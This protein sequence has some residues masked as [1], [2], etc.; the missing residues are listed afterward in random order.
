[1]TP[2][3]LSDIYLVMDRKPEATTS[4]SSIP[5]DRLL[6]VD[7]AAT[8]DGATV[9]VDL[10]CGEGVTPVIPEATH[11]TPSELE[12][13][14]ANECAAGMLTLDQRIVVTAPE[15]RVAR[16]GA[17]ALRD[18]GFVRTGYLDG[19]LDEWVRL[20]DIRTS[21]TDEVENKEEEQ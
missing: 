14:A 10:R 1:M 5:M 12:A 4:T 21:S 18:L 7:V 6:A 8:L 16:L 15:E 3:S 20:Q 9:V 2:Q 17:E 11:I 13:W 19:G